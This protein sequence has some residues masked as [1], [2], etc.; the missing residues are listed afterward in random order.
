MA[1]GVR[2]GA[3]VP[4]LGGGAERGEHLVVVALFL[5]RRA[6]AGERALSVEAAGR[7]LAARL[8]G[9]LFVLLGQKQL[10]RKWIHKMSSESW[11]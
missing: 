10:K 4:C 3:I 1:E 5:Q 2:V 9:I 6:Q 11:Q 7:G 8:C